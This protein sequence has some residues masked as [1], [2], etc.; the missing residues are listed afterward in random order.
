M[1]QIQE[2][3][4][5]I[6]VM[7]ET[8]VLVVGSGPGG[9]AAAIACAREGVDTM[10]V[11][12]WGSFGGNITQA[13]VGSLAWYRYEKTVEAGGIGMEFERCADEMGAAHQSDLLQ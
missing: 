1:K 4:R 8:D 2:P 10:I 12:R 7:A 9:L 3:A 6:P 13:L 5:T 11:E